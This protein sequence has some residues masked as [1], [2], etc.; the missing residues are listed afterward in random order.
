VEAV[1]AERLDREVG[2]ERRVDT[3]REAEDRALR[4]GVVDDV[5]DE[6]DDALAGRRQLVVREAEVE[7]GRLLQNDGFV[8][9][10]LGVRVPV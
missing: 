4:A 10:R 2:G 3:A 6:R 5:A 1:L 7:R 8:A 9:H